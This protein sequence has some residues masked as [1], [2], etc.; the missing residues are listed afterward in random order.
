MCGWGG[1]GMVWIRHADASVVQ[2]TDRHLRSSTTEMES[3]RYP[4]YARDMQTLDRQ[5]TD[6]C[7]DSQ[8][9]F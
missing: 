8:T 4:T 5:Q 2:T 3:G 1:G 7:T 9:D 6:I